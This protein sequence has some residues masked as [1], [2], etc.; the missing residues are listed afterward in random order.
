MA[1]KNE[2]DDGLVG[3]F[4]ASAAAD[5]HAHA[6]GNERKTHASARGQVLDADVGAAGLRV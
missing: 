5:S 6:E 1:L 3:H 4:V 2:A